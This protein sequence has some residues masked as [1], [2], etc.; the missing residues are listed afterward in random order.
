[1]TPGGA[2]MPACV[3]DCTVAIAWVL[4][5]ERTAWTDTML[6]EIARAGAIVPGL[7]KLET[8]NVLLMAERR[9]RITQVQR[10]RALSALGMLPIEIDDETATH[11]WGRTLESA[12]AHHL[13]LYDAA[14]LELAIRSSLPLV[15]LDQALLRAA[16]SVGVPVK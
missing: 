14:Y 4:P 9:R 6:D 12:S 10:H 1:M 5:G 7:W 11:A 3:L 15:T 8:A 13:T 16:A 2:D